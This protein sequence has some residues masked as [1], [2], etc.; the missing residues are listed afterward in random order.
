MI[1]AGTGG[2]QAAARPSVRVSRAKVVIKVADSVMRCA[3]S[4]SR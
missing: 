2:V 4:R 3:M 1:P